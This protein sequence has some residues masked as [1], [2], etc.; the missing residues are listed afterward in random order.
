MVLYSRADSWLGWGESRESDNVM[1]QPGP[2]LPDFD[3]WAGRT[4]Q[5]PVSRRRKRR[6]GRRRSLSIAR[7]PR[8]LL[9]GRAAPGRGHP[10]RAPA[11]GG[12]ARQQR[13]SAV[14]ADHGAGNAADKSAP[15]PPGQYRDT[16]R[17]ADAGSPQIE[18]HGI[19]SQHKIY[20][21]LPQTHVLRTRQDSHLLRI[22]SQPA[23][24]VEPHQADDERH[25]VRHHP[26]DAGAMGGS[27]GQDSG[28]GVRHS[29]GTAG[30]QQH[31]DHRVHRP[32]HDGVRGPRQHHVVGARASQHL[33]GYSGRSAAAGRRSE[34]VADA[35]SRSGRDS[36]AEHSGGVCVG[37]SI[38]AI[39]AAGIVT[40][41][42][43][44][45]SENRPVRFPVHIGPIPQG[46]A[47]VIADSAAN[48]PA[49]A[50]P[51]RRQLADRGHAHQSQ[52]SL[53]QGAGHCRRQCR[54]G[55]IAAQA[56][57][58][59]S[60]MLTGAQSTIDNL[61]LPGKQAPDAAPRWARTDQTIA[62]WDYATADQL[63]GDGSAPLNVYFR[64]PPGHLL[65]R[66][67]Q[68]DAAPGLS[69]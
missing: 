54:P 66:A 43:G 37:A 12:Q 32:L 10:L 39:Q 7:G 59:H 47:I 22:F 42:F 57:A 11:A 9:A 27:D 45:I 55:M 20:F 5:K 61:K 14:A 16:F 21:T 3:A 35:V 18:L 13:P 24:A 25:A 50:E 26:A 63:Q 58:L 4:F 64:I 33:S 46:N 40:S 68:C 48:L 44:L 15:L 56:V 52:R 8:E 1:R 34:A 69:L 62:L 67:A 38:K 30:A 41:Y 31:A 2:H 29:A 49:G 65:H 17:L 53:Q 6:N 23:A 51:A 19:D 36:A 28:G 60:D